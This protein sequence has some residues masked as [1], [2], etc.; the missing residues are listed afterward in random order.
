[1][2]ALSVR[3]RKPWKLR[4][5]LTTTTKQPR[6]ET[7][8]GTQRRQRHGRRRMAWRRRYRR[9]TSVIMHLRRQSERARREH[10]SAL[11]SL[12]MSG[13]N[14]RRR[15]GSRSSRRAVRYHSHLG[16]LFD[17]RSTT[18]RY[19]RRRLK[20]NSLVPVRSTATTRKRWPTCRLWHRRNQKRYRGGGCKCTPH[21]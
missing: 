10:Q 8:Q 21:G 15:H 1:M 16:Y 9:A 13:S 19:S 11:V 18:E 2:A 7:D 4:R 12:T 3:G 14:D 6:N 17:D 5:R 20:L